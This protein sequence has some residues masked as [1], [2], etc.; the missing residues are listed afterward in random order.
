LLVDI[1]DYPDYNKGQKHAKA[2]MMGNYDLFETRYQLANDL[3][4]N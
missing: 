3:A 1:L 4:Q 2:N